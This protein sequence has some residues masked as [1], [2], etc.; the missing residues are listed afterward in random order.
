[1][2]KPM[3][4]CLRLAERNGG[5]RR[6]KGRKGGRERGRKGERKGER[7]KGR[8]G[9]REKGRKGDVTSLISICNFS[10]KFNQFFVF[11]I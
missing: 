9:E 8:K 11:F 5:R 6:E 1:M 10:P 2:K 7:E 3:K 4:E